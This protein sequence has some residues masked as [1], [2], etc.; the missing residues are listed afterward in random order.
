MKGTGFMNRNAYQE[1]RTELRRQTL[2]IFRSYV[3]AAAVVAVFAVVY[4]HFGHGVQSFYMNFAWIWPAAGALAGFLFSLA[5]RSFTEPG[6]VFLSCGLATLTVG[7]ILQGVFEI[8]GT[9]SPFIPLF[10]AA[11]AALSAV[12]LILL[13]AG[14]RRI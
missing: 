3:I 1:R 6:R 8:A 13:I 14:S 2:R 12:A 4:N 11:G 9:N 7:F 5:D 10:L